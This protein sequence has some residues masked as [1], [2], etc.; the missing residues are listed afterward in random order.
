MRYLVIAAV[1]SF[2]SL[3]YSAPVPKKAPKPVEAFKLEGKYKL[4]WGSSEWRMYFAKGGYTH[5]E[6]P[7]A[8]CQW[9]GSFTYDAKEK[10]LLVQEKPSDPES[11]EWMFWQVTLNKDLKGTASMRQGNHTTEIDVSFT[12]MK[13]D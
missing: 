4:M 7:N 6:L 2:A 10:I 3:V 11:T 5:S 8:E 12:R 1:V 9:D 13:D